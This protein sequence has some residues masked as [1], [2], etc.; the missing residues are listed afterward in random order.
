MRY[1]IFNVLILSIL[2]I[3]KKSVGSKTVWHSRRKMALGPNYRAIFSHGAGKTERQKMRATSP[4]IDVTSSKRFSRDLYS[5]RQKWNR[6]EELRERETSF[7]TRE[8]F[9]SRSA[10]IKEFSFSISDLIGLKLVLIW[11]LE[12]LTSFRSLIQINMNI[13]R[14]LRR[15][16]CIDANSKHWRFH[17]DIYLHQGAEIS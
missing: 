10:R 1:S 13:F 14:V 5:T 9:G 6:K 8:S 3:T 12:M 2:K 11:S 17:K 7:L 4:E 16:R 15:S